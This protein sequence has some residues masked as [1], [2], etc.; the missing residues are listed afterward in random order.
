MGWLSS[1]DWVE[2]LSLINAVL[3]SAIVILSFAL[4]IY[5]LLYNL[6]SSVAR[7]FL[8]IFACALAVYFAD[9][10]MAGAPLEPALRWLRFQWIGIAFMPAAYLHSSDALL[11]T[12]NDRSRLRSLALRATYLI[13][14]LMLVGAVGTDLLVR[15]G[16]QEAGAPHL[17]A[18]P[19]FWLFILY[20]VPAVG[21]GA[22]N[23]LRAWQRC[24]TSTSRRRMTY[25]GLS[26][27][28]PAVGTFP[29]LLIAGWPRRLP[30][31]ALWAL[32]IVG[33]L[34]VGLMLVVLA[35]TVAFFGIVTPDRVVKHRFVRFL[36]RGPIQ[37]TVVV[38][39]IVLASRCDGFLGL[40]ALRL[41][42]FG[43]VA[44][45]LLVQVA[46][47]LAKPVIDRLLYRRDK[48]EIAWIQDLSNRLLTT[49]DLHQ[50]LENVL[51]AIC[52][53]LRA[54]TA[55]IATMDDGHPHL[56]AVCGSLEPDPG[57]LPRGTLEAIAEGHPPPCLQQHGN[58]FTWNG[59][60]LLPLHSRSGDVVTGI[61][62]AA[63]RATPPN[64]TE[65][66]EKGLA[67]L[68]LQAEAALEDQRIQKSLFAALE[69]M[70]P[71]IEDIQQRRSLL[72]YE[73]DLA[74]QGLTDMVGDPDFPRWVRDALS[75]YWGGPKLTRSPL[76]NLQIVE[77]ASQ[78]V[79][80][81][82]NALRAVLARAIERLRP[83]GDRSMT[84]AEW[85]LYNILE[86][87]FIRGYRVRDVAMRLAMSE[88]D[89]YR[90]QRIAIEEVARVLAEME[91]QEQESEPAL[92]SAEV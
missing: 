47:E 38:M 14:G 52:D 64:L 39:V 65:V 26:F 58:L 22:L 66:E 18:G 51:T 41:S 88:S 90:K 29:Y 57:F 40:P 67:A 16:V 2:H 13:G 73:G 11:Q 37:A 17:R 55:F 76:L 72:R 24:L 89:L 92:E 91:R 49:A 30:G 10:A 7:A 5:I 85:L 86:L 74:L 31:V 54:P 83:E 21:W 84:A 75:H 33:N 60:W 27:L 87:K 79:G 20:F 68:V 34:L 70:M 48:A 44:A 61:L 15:D 28:A 59:F 3:T 35:Y 46:I 42:L 4:L 45:I 56:V 77:R 69:Q 8:A 12:T 81:T 80:S 50:F 63:A 43:A 62:G 36:L 6:R 78:E 1:V 25:L 71:Q 32:L 82:V 9:L 53:L 19:Y 23:V